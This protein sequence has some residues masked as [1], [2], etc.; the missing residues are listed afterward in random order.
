MVKHFA[1]K[2]VSPIIRS[3]MN[4]VPV[5]SARQDVMQTADFNQVVQAYSWAPI[6]EWV[7]N[8]YYFMND[9]S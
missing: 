9:A 3:E 1:S 2:N 7:Q 4:R 6:T 5:L 8:P